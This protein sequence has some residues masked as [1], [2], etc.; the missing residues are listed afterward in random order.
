MINV[1]KFSELLTDISFAEWQKIKKA[2]DTKY[3]CEL[4]KVKI[5]NSQELEK[6]IKLE[7]FGTIQWLFEFVICECDNFYYKEVIKSVL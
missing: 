1:E 4:S 2:V 3:S 5:E 7:L 6:Q